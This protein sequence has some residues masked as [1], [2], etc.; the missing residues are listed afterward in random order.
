MMISD[1]EEKGGKQ[2]GEYKVLNVYRWG[3]GR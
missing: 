1:K 3:G 2:E